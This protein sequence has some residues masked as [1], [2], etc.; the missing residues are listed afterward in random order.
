MCPQAAVNSHIVDLWI[1]ITL[2]QQ[3]ILQASHTM[4]H[5]FNVLQI[6]VKGVENFALQNILQL[7]FALRYIHGVSHQQELIPCV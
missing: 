6:G 5:G 7:V 2:M 1:N 3:E 4:C